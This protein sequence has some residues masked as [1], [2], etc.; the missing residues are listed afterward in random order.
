MLLFLGS[1]DNKV[2]EKEDRSMEHPNLKNEAL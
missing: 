2:I 1:F